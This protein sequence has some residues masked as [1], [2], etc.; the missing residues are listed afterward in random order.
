MES[1]LMKRLLLAFAFSAC[2][3]A[4]ASAQGVSIGPRGVEVDPGVG[5]PGY[6]ERRWERERR[7]DRER[8]YG[9]YEDG[10]GRG[11]CRTI[12]IR[13][14]DPYGNERVKRI[15]RCG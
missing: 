15:R 14:E 3:A 11:G 2:A 6:E 5:R 10:Y 7:W 12:T 13:S 8:R 4:S 9:A 1:L